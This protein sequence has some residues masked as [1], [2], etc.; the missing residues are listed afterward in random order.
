MVKLRRVTK[1]FSS[2]HADYST[3][4]Q[5]YTK[6]LDML[7]Q[8]FEAAK[9]V[10]DGQLS[11]REFEILANNYKKNNYDEHAVTKTAALALRYKGKVLPR[12]YDI[13]LEHLPVTVDFKN[14]LIER[15]N[16][17]YLSEYEGKLIISA[18]VEVAQPSESA[19]VAFVTFDF[20]TRTVDISTN[21]PGDVPQ[22]IN[23][24]IN[25]FKFV[26]DELYRYRKDLHVNHFFVNERAG[27]GSRFKDYI[28]QARWVMDL[29]EVTL[30]STQHN[31][32]AELAESFNYHDIR[33]DF[34]EVDFKD[35]IFI[36]S[37]ES[38]TRPLTR[39]EDE[40]NAAYNKFYGLRGKVINDFPLGYAYSGLKSLDS[41][42]TRRAKKEGK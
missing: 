3:L 23:Y 11:E 33:T 10:T 18:E 17:Y 35:N 13:P 15:V 7:V 27:F 2:E 30:V 38:E 32:V 25:R 8:V 34:E 12:F 26:V 40:I 36:P 1:V 24:N 39:T 6:H 31:T 5:Y 28:D 4:L 21:I 22:R 14:R 37:L 9:Q 20:N 42:N 19:G 16:C 41:T 29:P